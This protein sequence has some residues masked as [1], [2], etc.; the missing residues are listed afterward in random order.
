MITD[1]SVGEMHFAVS[2]QTSA[3]KT[4]VYAADGSLKESTLSYRTNEISFTASYYGGMSRKDAMETYGSFNETLT[5]EEHAGEIFKTSTFYEDGTESYFSGAEHNGSAYLLS[6]AASEGEPRAAFDAFMDTV[7]F[8]Q[9]EA[10]KP[11]MTFLELEYSAPADYDTVKVEMSENP[12]G[13]GLT[14]KSITWHNAA[15]NGNNVYYSLF[16]RKGEDIKWSMKDELDYAETNV[17]GISFMAAEKDNNRYYLCQRGKD[18]YCVQLET[19]S[20]EKPPFDEF[21]NSLRFAE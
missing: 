11:D 10:P 14:T 7:R 13:K 5:D 18:S 4:A 15:E 12:V 19:T 21:I 2:G 17:N 20:S 8:E 16:F 1:T 9:T 3:D 6:F